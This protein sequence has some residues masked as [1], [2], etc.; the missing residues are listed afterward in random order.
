[1]LLFIALLIPVPPA[2][3]KSFNTSHVVIYLRTRI[4][5]NG[6][7]CSFNTSHVVIYP[8]R[9][10]ACDIGKYV[11]IHLM[12]LFIAEVRETKKVIWKFQYISCCYL[13]VKTRKYKWFHCRFNT[14]HV[15][16]YRG[17]G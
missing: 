17:V 6:S 12:L 2:Y 9:V 15:V 11:S 1:M 7:K 10:N 4:C 16:I 3:M 8:I 13:S 5:R 14:S